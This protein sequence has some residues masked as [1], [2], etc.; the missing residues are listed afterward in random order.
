[1]YIY[2]YYN[3]TNRKEIINFTARGNEAAAKYGIEVTDVNAVLAKSDLQKIRHAIQKIKK[4]DRKRTTPSLAE[5]ARKDLRHCLHY[6]VFIDTC[7]LPND[8]AAQF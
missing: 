6:K 3:C 4:Q 8:S 1:M 7:S 5:K 2:E